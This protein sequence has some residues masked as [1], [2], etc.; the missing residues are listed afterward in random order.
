M[1]TSVSIVLD[2]MLRPGLNIQVANRRSLGPPLE[3]VA[4]LG[5]EH[6]HTPPA[7]S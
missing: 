7:R 4:S 6:L 3:H 1:R 5:E 2:G